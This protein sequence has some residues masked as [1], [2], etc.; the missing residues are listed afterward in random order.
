[1]PTPLTLKFAD[2]LPPIVRAELEQLVSTLQQSTAPGQTGKLIVM[3]PS[4]IVLYGLTGK[5]VRSTL[6][7]FN[8]VWYT[9]INDFIVIDFY[10]GGLVVTGTPLVVAL[11]LPRPFAL[12]TLARSV[13]SRCLI[14]DAGTNR[15]AN[16]FTFSNNLTYL[17][18]N[19]YFSRVDGGTFTNG[20]SFI[21]GQ[22][23]LPVIRT[24]T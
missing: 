3:P 13:F 22:V 10:L 23:T 16:V 24:A 18:Q 11:Q 8:I 12:H 19:L 6:P 5:V 4:S 15:D 2:Q 14:V 20:T 9:I 1:M 21:V 17:P 7:D